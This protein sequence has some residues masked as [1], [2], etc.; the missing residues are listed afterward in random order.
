MS[1][2]KPGDKVIIIDSQ[3]IR[4]MRELIGSICTVKGITTYDGYQLEGNTFVWL[5]SWLEFYDN[6]EISE[7][8]LM[9]CF[10]NTI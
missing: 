3:D 1:K 10:K 8:D 4:Q 2:F 9:N 6:Y 5:E 7:T